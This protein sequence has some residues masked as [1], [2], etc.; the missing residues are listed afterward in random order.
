MGNFA[1]TNIMY[2]YEFIFMNYHR[3]SE[4]HIT[5][6]ATNLF[7]V[8]LFLM[9]I[10]LNYFDCIPFFKNIY[11]GFLLKFLLFYFIFRGFVV[12]GLGFWVLGL[13]FRV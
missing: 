8:H 5:I 12:W 4:A 6:D 10:L 9:A 3:S 11:I 1:K 2:I 13:G 7:I